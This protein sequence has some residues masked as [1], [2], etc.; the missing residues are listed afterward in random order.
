M[1]VC[2]TENVHIHM[3]ACERECAYVC[4]C[5]REIKR[6]CMKRESVR[7]YTCF[8]RS[9]VRLYTCYIHMCGYVCVNVRCARLWHVQRVHSHVT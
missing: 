6:V 1:C 3:C 5:V 9:S 8:V 7:I 4:V 2:V